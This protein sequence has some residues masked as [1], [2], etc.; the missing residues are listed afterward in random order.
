MKNIVKIVGV[1]LVAMLVLSGCRTASVYNTQ[2]T[3]DAGKSSKAVY[4]AIKQA[5]QSLG[6]N[7]SK[8]SEGVAIGKLALRTHMAVVRI[9]YNN[10]SYKIDYKDSQNLKYNAADNT[11]HKNYNGWVQNLEK[12]I[13]VRL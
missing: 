9:T 12:A 4:T 13:N 3:I 8:V 10:R 5:G 7:I 2:N 11:I 1:A 6:W